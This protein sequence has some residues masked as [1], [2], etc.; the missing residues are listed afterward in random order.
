MNFEIPPKIIYGVN[1]LKNSINDISKLGKIAFVV[2]GKHLT[3][4]RDICVLTDIL[5]SQNIKYIIYD[6]IIGEPTDLMV[7]DG[8]EIYKY[9][10]CDFLI[11]IGGGSSIDAMKAIGLIVSNGG[12][13]SDYMS[14]PVSMCPPPMVAIPTTAGTGSEATSVTIITDTKTNIKMLIKSDL[15]MPTLA[16]VDSQLT[17]SAP[18]SVTASTGLDAL[19]HAVEA[20]TSKK[21]Q[22]LTDT[23]AISAV[24]RIFKF[25]PSAYQNG[26]DEVARNEMSIS[27]L[28]AGI[29][30]SNSSVTLVHG[31]SRPI[32]AIF[33]IPHGLSNAILLPVCLNY[34]VVGAYE[35]FA[36]L[37]RAIGIVGD[38]DKMVANQFVN[39]VNELCRFCNVKNLGNYDVSKDYFFSMLD[40]MADDALNSGSPSNT[41]RV[42]TKDDIIMLYKQLW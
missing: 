3:Q 9:N 29:A 2:T 27:A 11:G 38:N 18:Q 31:M 42:P 35:R 15:L 36:D 16:V 10:K 33:H 39:R 40:K 22:P 19:T 5:D 23:F 41:R 37:G 26:S 34:A 24:K 14:K 8:V 32:G 4:N 17:V 12:L 21:A 20:Y 1:S 28:E 25:L 6:N 7:N 30:F 13:C